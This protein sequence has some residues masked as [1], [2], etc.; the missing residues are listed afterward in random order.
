MCNLFSITTKRKLLVYLQNLVHWS[1]QPILGIRGNGA[2]YC[3]VSNTKSRLVPSGGLAGCLA[4]A[5]SWKHASQI[6]GLN[7]SR[8]KIELH[9]YH[10]QPSQ[11]LQGTEVYDEVII[12]LVANGAGYSLPYRLRED[13]SLHRMWWNFKP[14][15]PRKWVGVRSLI[16][17]R[18]GRWYTWAS[19][20]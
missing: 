20:R 2:H 1:I 14:A 5:V 12:Y 17:G 6:P 4:V 10:R 9:T 18:C 16:F 8:G 3:Q 13:V 7:P 15:L 19:K 11:P